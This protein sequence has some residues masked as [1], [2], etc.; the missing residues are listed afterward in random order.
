MTQSMKILAAVDRS[1]FGDKVI[2]MITRVA[3]R[4][5]SV[6]LLNVAGEINGPTAVSISYLTKGLSWAPSYRI[7]ITDPAGR[8]LRDVRHAEALDFHPATGVL[9]GSL[10]LGSPSFGDYY[11]ERLAAIDPQSGRAQELGIISNS[12]QDDADS[13]GFDESRHARCRVRTPNAGLPR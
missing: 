5:T 7:D 6:L 1:P 2:D 3:R 8:V 12:Y 9:Y 4:E 11:S 13:F 10:N